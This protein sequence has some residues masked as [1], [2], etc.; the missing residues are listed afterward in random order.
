MLADEQ[1]GSSCI[2]NR[3]MYRRSPVS[4]RSDLGVGPST[5]LVLKPKD[6]EVRQET[7]E[8][9]DILMRVGEEDGK[10]RVFGHRSTSEPSLS[11]VATPERGNG[12]RAMVILFAQRTCQIGPPNVFYRD[13][14]SI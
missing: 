13:T 4:T 1:H 9:F 2:P 8:K 5:D 11:V 12:S 14:S 6:F 3:S 7:T 10:P